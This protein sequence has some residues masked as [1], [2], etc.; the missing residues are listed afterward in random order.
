M[1]R[2]FRFR[3]KTGRILLIYRCFCEHEQRTLH[4]MQIVRST[5]LDLM[6]VVETLNATNEIFMKLPGRGDGITRYALPSSVFAMQVEEV[7]ALVQGRARMENWVFWTIWASIITAFAV[8]SFVV[9]GTMFM[10]R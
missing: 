9:F 2:I 5:G 6:T 1:F 3:R 8:A 4:P 7:E 10:Q